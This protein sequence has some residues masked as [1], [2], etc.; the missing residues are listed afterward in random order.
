MEEGLFPL[1]VVVIGLVGSLVSASK[2]E[3]EQKETQRRV[4]ASRTTQSQPRPQTQPTRMMSQP[5]PAQH[6]VPAQPTVHAHIQPDCVVH[7]APGSLN[8]V[9]PEGKDPCHEAQ[10]T[11]ARTS[12]DADDS[13]PS[14]TLDWTGENLVKS[15]VMQEILT[16]PCQRRAR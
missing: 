4:Q 7:D 13:Q 3:R 5:A 12:V 8:V 9:S 10:L 2:K 15:F 1:L 14:L 11:H 6:A 16:R